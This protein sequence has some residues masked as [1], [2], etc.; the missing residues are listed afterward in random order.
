MKQKKRNRET[1]EKQI[2]RRISQKSFS[3]QWAGGFLCF[4]FH[5][6]AFACGKSLQLERVFHLLLLFL[7]L[8]LLHPLLFQAFSLRHQHLLLRH[9]LINQ[10]FLA[11]CDSQPHYEILT[12][13]F[14]AILYA[15]M[16]MGI[17]L[18]VVFIACSGCKRSPISQYFIHVEFCKR[19]SAVGNLHDE[20]IFHNCRMVQINGHE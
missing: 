8:P 17:E 10:F 4:P 3:T 5:S 12:L 9:E 2:T 6:V 7:P 18:H 1:Q 11:W 16:L 13:R 20:H 19:Q 14:H 15:T